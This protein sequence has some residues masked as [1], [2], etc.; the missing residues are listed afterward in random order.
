MTILWLRLSSALPSR[1]FACANRVWIL[2][3]PPAGGVMNGN[4]IRRRLMVFA[5]TCAVWSLTPAMVNAQPVVNPT[6]AEFDPSPDHNAT[7]S[8]GSAAV[9][10]YDLG[11]Y[12]VGAASPVQVNSLGKPAPQLDGKIRAAIGAQPSPGIT[13]EARVS[14]VGPGGATPSTVSNTFSFVT[15]SYTVSPT[16]Q[17]FA[18]TGGPASAAVT[19]PSGCAWTATSNAIWITI[20]SGSSGSG[21]GTTNYSVTANTGAQRSGTLTIAGQTVTVTQ[22]AACSFT[23]S[24]TTQTVVS[25]GG[26][27]S[28]AVTTAAGCTWTATS[29]AA[30][31]TITSGSS[32][33]GNGTVNYSSAANTTT[34]QRTGTLTVA[35][36]TVTVTQSAPCTFT[37]SPTSQSFAAAGGTATVTVT[38]AAGCTWTAAS[39]ATWLTI[40]AGASGSGNGTVS[41]SAAGQASTTERVGTL[42]VAGQAVTVTQAA[43]LPPAPPANVRITAF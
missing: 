30:W 33:S 7:L 12:L 20:T 34:A 40:T 8:D 38:T 21:N 6:T 16:T 1:Y 41:Y 5:L 25:A 10:R 26:P 37:V 24:P 39:S 31:I 4:G 36:K 22:S 3:C 19:A 2:H 32:G 35:G 13:Y 17:T 14:A 27:A 28:T 42:T 15:C 11:F 29:N 9:S 23:V 18:G 43:V